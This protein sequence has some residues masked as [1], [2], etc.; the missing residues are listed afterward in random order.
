MKYR[1]LTSNETEMFSFPSF[2][3]AVVNRHHGKPTFIRRFLLYCAVALM[4]DI[5][6][7]FHPKA[8]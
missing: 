1:R 4:P 3:H 6:A 8:K 7:S 2:F 5:I